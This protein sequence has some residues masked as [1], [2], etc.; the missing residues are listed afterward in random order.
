MSDRDRE[1]RELLQRVAR[2]DR[3]A[4][5]ELYIRYHPRLLRFLVRHAGRLDQVEE[6]INDVMLVVWQQ[7]A[8]FRGGSRVSTWILGV[9]YRKGLKAL[10]RARRMPLEAPVDE[11]CLID[12]DGPERQL[13]R[14]ELRDQV[15]AA[16][17]ALPVEQRAAVELTF[18][19]GCSYREIAAIMDCPENTVK[20]RMFHARR[21]LHRLLP[22]LGAPGRDRR[23]GV[24]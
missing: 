3:R 22:R 16:L 10:E 19:H 12:S 18:Y 14:R 20:T 11:T 23:G 15:L 9:A 5:D 1:E 6:L 21:K 8:A 13:S 24:G 4:F 7:A 2:R 17:E